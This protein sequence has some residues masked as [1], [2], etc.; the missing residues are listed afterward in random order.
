MSNVKL[1][2][3]SMEHNCQCCNA[4]CDCT[5]MSADDC[6]DCSECQLM[7]NPMCAS[8]YCGNDVL[9]GSLYCKECLLDY[10]DDDSDIDYIE[11]EC[12]TA[13]CRKS[14]LPDSDFCR[15]CE[16]DLRHAAEG[17]AADYE[18]CLQDLGHD[19]E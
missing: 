15:R 10:S 14:P 6:F 1:I 11:P 2:I 12:R 3:K 4:D 9:E 17:D 8:G 7:P 16:D 5:A 18:F 13:N 19:F